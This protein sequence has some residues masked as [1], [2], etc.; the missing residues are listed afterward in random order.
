MALD[1]ALSAIQ[2]MQPN[3]LQVC[4][5]LESSHFSSVT[6][7]RTI[8]LPCQPRP[9]RKIGFA[10]GCRINTDRETHQGGTPH[11]GETGQ[12]LDNYFVPCCQDDLNAY[13][14]LQ[15][16]P[17]AEK[18]AGVAN[19]EFYQCCCLASALQFHLC[20]VRMSTGAW[21]CQALVELCASVDIL[22]KAMGALCGMAVGAHQW[23][24][25]CL[26]WSFVVF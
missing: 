20:I 19:D 21:C 6:L 10:I 23:C 15:G 11:V 14:L 22:D 17:M 25:G 12:V 4:L 3:I 7:N 1:R 5:H 8:W 24:A 18:K 13:S 26:S 2:S 9:G 16:V